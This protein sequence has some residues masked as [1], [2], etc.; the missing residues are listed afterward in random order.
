MNATAQTPGDDRS[1]RIMLDGAAAAAIAAGIALLFYIDI[2][3]PRGVVDGVG[4]AAVVAIS[5]RFGRRVLTGCAVLVTALIV[6]AATLLPDSG[7]SVEGELANRFFAI[8][9]VWIVAGVLISRLSLEQ[10]IADRETRL[11]QQQTALLTIM[12]EALLTKRPFDDRIRLVT[13]IAGK[14]I[15]A[16]R[17][18]VLHSQPDKNTQRS[19]DMWTAADESHSFLPEHPIDPESLYFREIRKNL[20]LVAD[21][22]REAP[23][24]RDLLVELVQLDVRAMVSVSVL[25]EGQF[26]GQVIVGKAGKPHHWTT[27]EIAFCRTLA[28]AVGLMF[29][30][31]RSERTLAALDLVGEGIYTTDE[32]GNVVYA[33]RVAREVAAL[34]ASGR[35]P[36]AAEPLSGAADLHEVRHGTMEVELQRVRLPSGGIITRINDVSARNMAVRERAQLQSRLQQSA[37][38]EAVG[39]L[40]G[41]VAHDFNNI[42]GSIMGF[43]GFLE[44]DL[45]PNSVERNY[46]QRI[47]AACQRG[48]SLIEQ[49]LDFARARVVE[50]GIVDLEQTLAQAQERLTPLLPTSITL[51]VVA[52][53]NLA[54][55]AGSA[56][57]LGQMI[58]NLGMNA[59][60]AIGDRSGTVSLWLTRATAAEIDGLQENAP[61]RLVLGDADPLREY[62]CLC[63]KDTGDGIAPEILPRIFEPFFTTKGRQRGTGLGLAVVH[64]IATAHG[65][66]CDVQSE[67]GKGTT[68]RIYLPLARAQV[69]QPA[70]VADAVEDIHGT[71]RILVVD[72]EADIVD[73]LT[74]GLIRLGYDAIGVD[75]PKEV[76]ESLREDP[77]ICEVIVTD[78]VMPSMRGL[79]LI[80]AVKALRP[81]LLAILCTGFSDGADETVSLEAG[82]DGFFRKPVDATAIARKIRQL[83]AE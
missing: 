19:L 6:V 47:L 61:G 65:G 24:L 67:L 72:D 39:Q 57:Q 49:I 60:D 59:R 36:A 34:D 20:A 33:N 75:D 54:F 17:V 78:Q 76:L 62:A 21:D 80:R 66:V 35:Y 74:I 56:T 68:F 53:A 41:G 79:E 45:P 7:I 18:T 14:A 30:A 71:E 46:A 63:I 77:S 81:D 28:S 43:A 32:A 38:M 22:V 42:L 58:L 3:Y 31:D 70:A 1:R 83:R 26:T 5:I 64:G 44:Q 51:Q 12:R 11:Q 13:E 2:T 29:A 37:K 9:S 52:N 50:R 55:V 48:K 10:F 69:S 15:N 25:V 16:S 40:A 73:M 4:Y 27:E 8:V 82:A 23:F